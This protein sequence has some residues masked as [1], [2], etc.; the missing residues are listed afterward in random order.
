MGKFSAAPT[1]IQTLMFTFHF[2]KFALFYWLQTFR[3]KAENA[4]S[5]SF[6]SQYQTVG[7]ASP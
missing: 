4:F 7:C 5:F 3:I 2:E 6:I 1:H